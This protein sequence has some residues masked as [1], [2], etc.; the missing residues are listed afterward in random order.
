MELLCII[1]ELPF[2]FTFILYLVVLGSY[3]FLVTAFFPVTLGHADFFT[4]I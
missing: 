3:S 4:S 1:G 2:L